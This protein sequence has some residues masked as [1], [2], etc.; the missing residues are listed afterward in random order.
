MTLTE[1]RYI[2]A[3][4]D[5]KHFGRAASRCFVSQPT[6]SIGVKRL[7]DELGVTL[8]ERSKT[9]VHLTALAE[10]LVEKARGILQEVDSFKDLSDHVKDPFLAPLR[11]GAIYTIGPYLFPSLLPAL[12]S[13]Q[14]RLKLFIE[15]SFTGT[16]RQMLKKGQLDAIIIALPFNEPDVEV[17][18]LYQEPFEVLL[19]EN[20]P[21]TR[22]QA[23]SPNSLSS[24]Q[25]LMLGEGH[26]LRDQVMDVCPA[27]ARRAK[28]GNTLVTEGS[29]LETL[30]HMVA[31]GLGLTVL[32]ASAAGLENYAPGYLVTRPFTQPEPSR[33]VALAWRRQFPR[34]E[35]I[36]LLIDVISKQVGPQINAHHKSA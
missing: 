32:P 13:R 12:K 21:M 2:V 7:E 9:G 16:L 11:I 14:P 35:A 18:P 8:F 25:V 23:I 22:Q 15:E 30:R 20:H 28:D 34:M 31:S 1:L 10:Q 4:A 3:V 24:D 33:T 36:D 5:E 27:L 29:S 19:P 26:C 17:K 6:L